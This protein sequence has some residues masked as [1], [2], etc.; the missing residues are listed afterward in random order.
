MAE[1]VAVAGV[2]ASILQIVD[3]TTKVISHTAELIRSGNDAL[4]ENIETERLALHYESLGE[5]LAKS[6]RSI[7][8]LH[9]EYEKQLANLGAKCRQEGREL[10]DQLADL[11]VD[12]RLSGPR[13]YKESVRQATRSLK[14]R[15]EIER[16][17]QSLR[18]LNGLLATNMLQLLRLKEQAKSSATAYPYTP[19]QSNAEN[20]KLVLLLAE[21]EKIRHL[22]LKLHFQDLSSRQ[23][24]IVDIYPDTYQ[25]ALE[26]NAYKFSPW[27]KDGSGIFW[28][29]GKP[30]SGKS[31]L[32]RF[33]GESQA[34]RDYLRAWSDGNTVVLATFYFWY[35]GT[36]LQKSITGLL[37]SILYQLLFLDPTWASLA[38]PNDVKSSTQEFDSTPWTHE[39]LRAAIQSVARSRGCGRRKICLFIDGLDEFH[40]NHI[41]LVRLVTDLATNPRLKLCV[42]SRPWNV[43]IKAFE[44]SVPNLCLQDLT[45]SDIKHYVRT[46][47]QTYC[48]VVDQDVERLIEEVVTRAEGVF[49]WVVLVVRSI[50]SGLA[51]G[52][53]ARFLRHRVQSFPPDLEQY[54]EVMV[55]ARV[56]QAYQQQTHQALKLAWLLTQS[57]G[58]NNTRD[59]LELTW[60]IS[61][62]HSSNPD[63]DDQATDL[64]SISNLVDYWLISQNP[65]GLVGGDFAYNRVQEVVSSDKWQKMAKDTK[66]FL[67]KATKDLLTLAPNGVRVDFLHRTVYDFLSSEK[68]QAI[69]DEPLADL[70]A[71]GRVLHLL[72]LARFK[73]IRP[74]I[75]AAEGLYI[76]KTTSRVS[77]MVDHVDLSTKY[78][79][80]F[81]KALRLHHQVYMGCLKGEPFD[82][83]ERAVD[84]RMRD[85]ASLGSAHAYLRLEF[86]VEARIKSRLANSLPAV[87]WS[88][89]AL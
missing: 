25:W 18:E 30:G 87:Q 59:D 56:D 60:R 75:S 88:P 40:G 71:D 37:R 84:P 36:P 77:I 83:F 53:D 4:R 86:D 8:G 85:N 33:L 64:K 68:I 61:Q 16:R 29:T 58:S 39:Q 46:E 28:V 34:T 44:M 73:M 26:D 7:S 3:C 11:K 1:F 43:F 65:S 23:E 42:S 49:L 38:F 52:D 9:V 57:R 21:R 67:S 15:N 32:M 10:L 70:F 54:F 35:L 89:R 45:Q 24:T 19:R 47:I 27:L 6:E 78:L 76:L 22:L 2:L 13:K 17:R 69:L 81:R 48:A 12:S 79:T 80:Q 55:F 20:V 66:M 82:A 74:G 31:T 14:K 62:C 72:N 51:E 63:D 5:E 50:L 41:E